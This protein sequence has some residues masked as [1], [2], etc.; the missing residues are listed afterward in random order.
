MPGLHGLGLGALA[1]V[2]LLVVTGALIFR[3]LSR[4][5]VSPIQELS[6]QAQ[7]LRAGDFDAPVGISGDLEIEILGSTLEEARQRIRQGIGELQMLN[8]NLEALV[9]DRTRELRRQYAD[10]ELLHQVAAAANEDPRLD[11][12][13][14]RALRLISQHCSGRAAAL[15]AYPPEGSSRSWIHPEGAALPWRAT[16]SRDEMPPPSPAHHAEAWQERRLRYGGALQADL[17]LHGGAGDAGDAVPEALENQLAA[18]LHGAFLLEREHEHAAQRQVLVARLLDASEEERRRIARELHD[19]ISQLLTVVQLGIEPLSGPPGALDKVR[20]LLTRTLHEIHRIIY[21]LRPSVLDDLGLATAI[22]WHAQ[23]H[24]E[25]AGLSVSLAV[26]EGLELSPEVEI[27]VFR[28]YQEIATNVLR[29]AAAEHVSV[30]LFRDD[31]HLV[32]AV[33]DDGRGF[34]P[35]EKHD[36]V[37]L[38]GMRERAGLVGGTLAID[39]EPGEGAR[40]RLD[41]PLPQPRRCRRCGEDM[42]RILIVDDHDL[43]REGIRAILERDPSSRWWA[44]PETAS[45]RCR[46]CARLRPDV[47]LMDV[48]LPGGLG[49]LEATE[50]ILAE[51]PESAGHHPHPVRAARVHPP[52]R[53]VSGAHGY[54]PKRSVGDAAGRGDPCRLPGAAIPAPGRRPGGVAMA[55]GGGGDEDEYER[56]TPREKQVLKLLAEGK[57]SREIARYLNISAEDGDDAPQPRHGEARPALARRAAEVRAEEGDRRARGRP[58]CATAGGLRPTSRGDRRG[59]RRSEPGASAAG[60]RGA[61]CGPAGRRPRAAGRCGRRHTSR[62][63]GR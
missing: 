28:I 63:G 33:E 24:L 59:G 41:V 51:R 46:W 49:G 6:R 30:E 58:A 34:E 43:V 56:L 36:G 26:D 17:Y 54:L 32:L 21:D 1:A 22:S 38:V 48:N 19:E 7:R 12:Y 13:V 11:S 55:T 35:D 50:A 42:I 39:S 45:R 8:D 40:V 2:A 16:A 37:G 47:V 20:A 62:P 31:G 10:L 14:P 44:R 52:R 15:V 5:V 9:A 57:T 23:S 61:G 3:P 60:R 18:T 4:S 53:C 25:E 29:H 27:C